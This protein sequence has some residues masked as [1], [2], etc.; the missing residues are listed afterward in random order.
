[1]GAAGG[2]RTGAED[3]RLPR[4]DRGGVRHRRRDP[5]PPSRRSR[6]VVERR[7]ALARRGRA[8]RRRRGD[9]DD[10]D[11]LRMALRLHRLL[12]LR[13]GI[14]ARVRRPR[15]LRRHDRPSA[16]LAR[17]PRLRRQADRRDRQRRHRGDADP[18]IERA[19]GER[20]DAAALADLHGLA[21]GPRRHRDRAAPAAPL[22]DRLLADPRQE[23]RPADAELPLQPPLPAA[24]AAPAPQGGRRRTAAGLSGRHPL[25]PALRPLG[26]APLPDPRRRPARGDLRRPRRDR[27]R[28]GR[29]VHRGGHPA[30][31]RHATSTPTSSSP[32]PVCSSS[33]SAGSKSSSTAARSTRP[34][35]SPTRR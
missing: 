14:H 30:P 3:P 8:D 1:M 5:L 18:G 25:Q 17:R 32:R 19:G 29:D 4:G 13:R 2:D 35:P 10:R 28:R 6:R 27:H 26:P 20:D 15:A 21:P 9:R 16:A 7:G 23:R 12:P 34:R 11:H 22:A 33:S 31:L 24:D